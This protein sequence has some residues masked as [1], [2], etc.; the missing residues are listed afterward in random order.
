MKVKEVFSY[1]NLQHEWV[2]LLAQ[3]IKSVPEDIFFEEDQS[4]LKREV[5]QFERK[6][7]KLLFSRFGPDVEENFAPMIPE[8][9]FTVDFILPT[10]PGTLV[11]VEKGKLPRLE[12][13]IMKIVNSICRYPQKYGFGCIVVPVN[14][15]KLNL[16]GRR[17]PYQFV[18]NNLIPLNSPVIDIRGKGKAPLVKD[19]VVIGYVDPRGE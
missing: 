19:F 9:Q 8:N 12:L 10:K 14:Y 11:E 17:S 18:T 1:R 13:D 3:S 16:A 4:P 5:I 15:I 6:L 2:S 7:F